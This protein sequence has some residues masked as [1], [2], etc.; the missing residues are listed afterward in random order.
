M[1]ITVTLQPYRSNQAPDKQSLIRKLTQ[2]FCYTYGKTKEGVE[3]SGYSNSHHPNHILLYTIQKNRHIVQDGK[4]IRRTNWTGTS[5]QYLSCNTTGQKE[6]NVFN[7]LI[8]GFVVFSLTMISLVHVI[9]KTDKT[10]HFANVICV[11]V[12]VILSITYAEELSGML[13]Y[14][15]TFI[16]IVV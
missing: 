1:K 5:R 16:G 15:L 2:G 14:L 12:S 11:M 13:S 4:R 6:M 9:C 3:Y 10:I 7:G 8:F